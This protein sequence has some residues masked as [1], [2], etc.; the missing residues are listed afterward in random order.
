M[1]EIGINHGAIKMVLDDTTERH[2]LTVNQ[3]PPVGTSVTLPF[4]V[5]LSVTDLDGLTSNTCT[6]R[7]Y[8]S[9][10]QCDTDPPV[11]TCPDPITVD[12]TDV[13]GTPASNPQ[14]EEWWS[15]LSITDCDS[16]PT[17]AHDAPACFPLGTTTVNWMVTDA[18]GNV[19]MC[20]SAVT[21]E[22]IA[23]PVCDV[24]LNRDCLWP[25][26]HKMADIFATVT[27]TGGCCSSSTLS[28]MSVTSNEPDN[29][30]GD[31]NTTGDIVIVS[32]THIRLRSE[33]SGQGDGRVYTLTFQIVDCYGN[34]TVVVK[35]VRVPHDQAGG[36]CAS[37]GFAPDGMAL[38]PA[39]KQFALV[40]RSRV[41]FDATALDVKRTYV[42]NV[43]GVVLPERSMEIDNNSD[44]LTDLAVFYSATALNV[45]KDEGAVGLHYRSGSGVDYLVPAIFN[46][47]EPVPL[48]PQVVIPR[49]N[50]SGEEDR[51]GGNAKVT[52]L[53]SIFPNPFNPSTMIPFSLVTQERVLLRVYSARGELVRRL[54]DEVM[55]VGLHQVLW[56]G[57]DDDGRQV[58]TGVYFVSLRAGVYQAT[59]KVVM[60]K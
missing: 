9:G 43:K 6:V 2:Q 15:S 30:V 45:L 33:R 24:D 5:T 36:A 37:N 7:F 11:V 53:F 13:C 48:V 18:A 23:P 44:G 51:H 17:V 8:D 38:D 35:E 27:G 47:G 50:D 19:G 40:I 34:T 58:A 56:D 28:L 59:R 21:V 14:L 4:D 60:I 20:S 25:P 3:V 10:C 54:K 16:D 31:G 57:L 26:N 22:D 39:L 46:L 49:G 32:D 12:R 29:G 52:A 1:P 42:G 41:D 55:P